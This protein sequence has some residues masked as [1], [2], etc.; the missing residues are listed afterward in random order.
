MIK[1]NTSSI[2]VTISDLIGNTSCLFGVHGYIVNGYCLWT[3]IDNQTLVELH[4]TGIFSDS[5]WQLNI[6]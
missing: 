2:N 5:N 3:V 4:T 6:N 1:T